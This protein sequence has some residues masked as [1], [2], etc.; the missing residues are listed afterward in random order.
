MLFTEKQEVE[1]K[2]WVAKRLEDMY[3]FFLG[4]TGIA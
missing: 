1:V 3:V 2:K 4:L